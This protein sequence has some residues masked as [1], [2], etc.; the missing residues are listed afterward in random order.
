MSIYNY[1]CERC[2][3]EKQVIVEEG[4]RLEDK[5]CGCHSVEDYTQGFVVLNSSSSA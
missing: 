2:G 5:I 1:S 4:E 3:N